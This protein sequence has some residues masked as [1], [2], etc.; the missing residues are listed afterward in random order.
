MPHFGRYSIFFSINCSNCSN[1]SINKIVYLVGKTGLCAGNSPGTGEFPA[2]KAS[3]AEN[4]SIWWRHHEMKFESK[5]FFFF[6]YSF[7]NIA[8]KMLAFCLG[9]NVL[10]QTGVTIIYHV[11]PSIGIQ[12][13]RPINTYRG[14]VCTAFGGPFN[15][16]A[17]ERC[18]TRQTSNI[19][20]TKSQNLNV[21]RLVLQLLVPIPLKPCG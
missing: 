19:S 3:N 7:E 17:P 4:V 11:N 1:C 5:Y 2:Q 10:K 16:L 18:S 8:S 20:C 15:T 6:K 13:D 12:G 14:V 9:S 21:S